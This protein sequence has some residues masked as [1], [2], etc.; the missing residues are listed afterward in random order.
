MRPHRLSLEAF[1]AFPGRVDV[2]FDRVGGGGLLLLCGETGGGKTTL[3]DALGFALFGRVPGLRGKIDGGPD[4]RSHHAAP[5]TRPWVTLEFTVA[6]DRYRITR[7][8]AWDRPRRGG[9]TSRAHPTAS[10]QRRA[11]DPGGKVR[12]R[13]GGTV[14]PETV[15]PD[16]LGPDTVGSDTLGPETVGPDTLG[17]DAGGWETLATRP[18]DVGHEIGQLLGMSDDQ[19]FQVVMLPQGRFADFLHAG[20]DDR[21]KLLKRLFRVNRF[22]FAEQWLRDRAK[23][24][25][26][27]LAEATAVLGRVA[28]RISQVAGVPLPAG[29][30]E[31]THPDWSAGLAS[32][33]GDAANRAAA[34]LDAART[35]LEDAEDALART[36]ELGRRIDRRR[37][38]TARRDEL[39][40]SRAAMDRLAAAADAARRA[41]VVTPALA[42]LCELADAAQRARELAQAAQ[43]RLDGHPAGLVPAGLVPAGLVP[44]ERE[45]A[46]GA[47]PEPDRAGSDGPDHPARIRRLAAALR[48]S[49]VEIGRLE[50]LAGVLADAERDHQDARVADDEAAAHRRD[51]DALDRRLTVELPA[52]RAA[53]DGR[54][55]AAHA[56]AADLPRLAERA[57]LARGLAGAADE[58]HLARAAADAAGQLARD[59]R[60]HAGQLRRDRFDAITSELAAM[61]ADDTP[62]PVCGA[63]DHPDPAEIRARQVSKEEELAAEREADRLAA[64][65]A[66]ARSTADRADERVLALH[67][68]LARQS[69]HVEG[70]DLAPAP[71]DHPQHDHPQHNHLQHNHLQR[72]HLQR[73]HPEPVHPEHEHLEPEHPDLEHPDL[74]H[75]EPEQPGP[76]KPRLEQ[77]ELE[78]LLGE[79]APAAVARLNDLATDLDE[80]LAAR[81][82]AAAGLAAA[83]ATVLDLRKEETATAKRS[84]ASRAAGEAAERRSAEARGRAEEKHAGLPDD[85]REAGALAKRRAAVDALATDQE[86]AHTSLV[87]A[88]QTRG[89]HLRALRTTL[90]LVRQ[91]G[92]ADPEAATAAGREETWLREADVEVRAHREET[93]AVAAALADDDLAVDPDSPVPLAEHDAAATVARRAHEAA[94]AEAARANQRA[95]ELAKLHAGYTAGFEALRPLR[96]DADELHHLAELAS[97]R[98]GNT[99]GMPLSSFVL[100]ARLEEVAIA[101]SHRLAAM[102]AGRFTLVHDTE[103]RRDR[104]RRAGLGLLVEDAWT[105][106]RRQ[107]GTLSGGETFQAALS[108]ALGLADVVTAEAG[109]RRLDTLFIDEG[110][111]SLDADSLDEVM[112][113]LD[114]LRSGGRLVGLVSHVTELRQ[115]I[116]NQIR[117]VKGTDGSRVETTS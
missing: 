68:D 84:S 67:A 12:P 95:G 48:R 109:G 96:A 20:H 86:A 57:R 103:E 34:A 116:P 65:A 18:Q 110:F 88:E 92:F 81:S 98:G 91:A 102:S 49:H 76:R 43:G 62:C 64:D 89:A 14:G 47:E 113:V 63:L 59:A 7:S 111:G 66:A 40:A 44:A 61:L 30:T 27:D 56:A 3:L 104:R 70:A 51:A 108:L 10:L 6:T 105:G 11:V 21:E 101:A 114:E 83:E 24:G 25:R 17:S 31:A 58:H 26:D 87:A 15:G 78:D 19:F 5:S 16:T 73:E 39:D 72:E 50:R 74:E 32:A 1:G 55:A 4:L 115:R 77:P 45:P 100:A 2:D 112:N 8:P 54:V 42:D 97:G 85:L 60:A 36:R 22:E 93:A 69:P 117:V 71:L 9:G 52:L 106:R 38:L 37:D 94:V 90:D 29:A 53:A 75:P 33:A 99:E 35:T 23:S 13:D 80:T 82:L 28:A 41:A 46:G 79:A 107:T